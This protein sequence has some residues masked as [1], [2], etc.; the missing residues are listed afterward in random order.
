MTIGAEHLDDGLGDRDGAI[1]VDGRHHV[2]RAGGIGAHAR[3][4]PVS[5]ELLHL[6]RRQTGRI[7]QRTISLHA[8]GLL[9]RY[10]EGNPRSDLHVVSETAVREGHKEQRTA[11]EGGN[12]GQ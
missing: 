4:Q 6:R 9:R 8:G 10:F 5:N 1:I 3:E 12:E 11:D 7:G 2:E